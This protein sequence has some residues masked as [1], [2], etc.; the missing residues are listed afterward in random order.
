MA[1]CTL[2]AHIFQSSSKTFDSPSCFSAKRTDPLP[3]DE[4]VG[5]RVPEYGD[6]LSMVSTNPA[7]GV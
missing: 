2:R 3:P 1:C 7:G 5:P 6:G 4:E